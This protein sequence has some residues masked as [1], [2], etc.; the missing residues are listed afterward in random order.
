MVDAENKTLLVFEL[1]PIQAISPSLAEILR[2]CPLQAAISRISGI[3]R[4]VLDNPKAW[5]GTAY[6]D[7]LEKL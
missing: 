3:K 5:L 1:K 6:Y 4:F 7:V 2:N